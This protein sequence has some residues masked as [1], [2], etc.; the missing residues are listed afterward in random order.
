[1]KVDYTWAL[2]KAKLERAIKEARGDR[3]DPN[4]GEVVG[5]KPFTEEEVKAIYVRLAGLLA[6]EKPASRVAYEADEDD[7]DEA[8]APRRGRARRQTA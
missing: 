5:N 7:E 2:N 4:I 3:N 8:P 1:M 6:S